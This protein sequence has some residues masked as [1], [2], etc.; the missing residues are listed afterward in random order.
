M[1]CTMFKLMYRETSDNGFQRDASTARSSSKY[2]FQRAHKRECSL[3][4]LRGQS[5]CCSMLVEVSTGQPEGMSTPTP[6]TPVPPMASH[7]DDKSE[8]RST[9]AGYDELARNNRSRA[10][11]ADRNA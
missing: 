11:A 2:G 3:R 7:S 9:H 6:I 8:Q 1:S 10:C 4:L 5:R